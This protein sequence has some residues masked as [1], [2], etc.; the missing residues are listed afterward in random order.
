MNTEETRRKTIQALRSR[1][2]IVPDGVSHDLDR[3]IPGPEV[4]RWSWWAA[5]WERP[6]AAD[7]TYNAQ[8]LAAVQKSW[9][10]S[11]R[12]VD[13][14]NAAS[15]EIESRKSQEAERKRQEA[16]KEEAAW[17]ESQL[18]KPRRAFLAAG[19]TP[20]AWDAVKKE[21]AAEIAKQAAVKAAIGA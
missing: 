20:E 18:A 14:Q 11:R 16:E 4:R 19:G 6:K 12:H 7:W 10:E 5:V 21:I 3:V 1:G 8:E 2:L 13:A 17:Q 15:A 9:D